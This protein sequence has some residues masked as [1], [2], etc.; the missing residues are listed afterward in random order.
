MIW[1][2]KKRF[3]VA[4]YGFP[5]E[6]ALTTLF[7]LGVLP[8]N[9]ALLTHEEEER[10]AG[11]HALARLRGV[12]VNLTSARDAKT[13]EW[14]E[15]F[16]PDALLSLHYR[17]L[18][19]EAILA[20]PPLGGVNLHPSLLPK[21]RGVNSV[22][23]TIINGETETGFTFHRMDA[24]F[25]TGAILVQRKI[26]IQPQETAF[27]LFNRQLTSAMNCLG[28]VIDMVVRGD[29]GSPQP[30]EGTYYPR[31]LPFGG[32]IDMSWTTEQ[33]ERFIRAMYFPPFPPAILELDGVLH[34]IGT[35]EDFLKVSGRSR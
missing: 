5:A 16:R 7:G 35:L 10:N 30:A 27:S 1:L 23:W 32:R 17:S 26:A 2:D 13:I 34:E 3:L 15:N 14:V 12:E 25:D 4:G 21:Y 9:V 8:E 22:P 29:P 6:F 18:I 31:A 20:I 24:K 11:L 33:V 19:H 28:E